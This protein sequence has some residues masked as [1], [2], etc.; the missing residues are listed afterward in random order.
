[1]TTCHERNLEAVERFA[2]SCRADDAVRAAFLGGSLA[3]GTDDEQSDLDLYVVVANDEALG[4]YLHRRREVLGAMAPAVYVSVIRDFEGLGFPMVLFALEDGVYGE[5]AVG[6]P[7]TMMRLHGGAHRVLDDKDGLLE[8]VEFPRHEWAGG[9]M[10]PEAKTLSRELDWFWR[11]VTE[12]SKAIARD[13]LWPAQRILGRMR[14][15]CS[16]LAAAAATP[17][18]RAAQNDELTA[19]FA[20]FD[21]ASIIQAV[22]A[23]AA[24]HRR[25]GPAV[26]AAAGVDYPEAH[27]KVACSRLFRTTGVL[28]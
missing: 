24:F 16:R 20:T 12:V 28:V 22:G 27:A 1:M 6:T 10:V 25:V 23:L 19:G 3:A 7:E 26:A 15:I 11:E 17:E 13:H 14:D 2:A 18:E 5:L 4:P 9:A 21:R 8:G